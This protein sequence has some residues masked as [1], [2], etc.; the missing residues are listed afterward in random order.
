MLKNKWIF[1]C[2]NIIGPVQVD[3]LKVLI[4]AANKESDAET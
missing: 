4:V 2:M 3:S 1:N